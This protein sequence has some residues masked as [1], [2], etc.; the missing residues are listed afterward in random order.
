MARYE[1]RLLDPTLGDPAVAEVSRL[2]TETAE[3][4]KESNGGHV[5]DEIVRNIV[6]VRYTTVAS[7]TNTFRG[8]GLRFCL[9][10]TNGELLATVLVAKQV[11][12]LLVADGGIV[13]KS[14]A[15]DALVPGGFH[16]IFNLAVRKSSRRHG[17][18]R[19]LL[20]LVEE[21]FRHAFPGRGLMMRV[22]PPD[23]SIFSKL[24]FR[25]LPA[26]D[27]FFESGVSLPESCRSARDYNAAYMCQCVDRDVSSDLLPE[28]KLKYF[29]FT[30]EFGG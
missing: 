30:R 15:P 26:Y 6:Q 10:A 19:M 4:L 20:S 1:L 8:T 13:N 14:F 23:H 29:V 22:E 21:D 25:H 7:I 17:L 12:F 2:L 28:Y 27:V 24:G 5:P 3:E 18:A 11:D 16:H 9:H